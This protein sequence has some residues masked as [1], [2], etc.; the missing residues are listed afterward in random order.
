MNRIEWIGAGVLFVL[1][2][3][4][5]GGCTIGFVAFQSKPQTCPVCP[6]PSSPDARPAPAPEPTPQ[7]RPPR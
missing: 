6:V 4:G 7:P 2:M 5:C 1:L 3:L